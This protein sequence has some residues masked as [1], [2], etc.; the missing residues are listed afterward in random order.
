L[1]IT[2]WFINIIF[3][4]NAPILFSVIAGFFSAIATYAAATDMDMSIYTRATYGR[5]QYM[6][7]SSAAFTWSL[8]AFGIFVIDVIIWIL[9]L[10]S[11]EIDLLVI[12]VL[13]FPS[14]GGVCV[15]VGGIIAKREW[16]E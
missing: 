13:C 1:L 16:D 5:S 12:L 2:S 3:R 8:V 4:A 6:G 7:E 11:V 14:V 9:L 10:P 15:L